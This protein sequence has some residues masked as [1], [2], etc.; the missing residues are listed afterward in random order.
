[1]VSTASTRTPVLR[2]QLWMARAPVTDGLPCN[3]DRSDEFERSGVEL[4]LRPLMVRAGLQA[5]KMGT[6]VVMVI[7]IEFTAHGL[8]LL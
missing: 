6:F 3:A 8:A 1:M 4:E 7:L 2:V 5:A